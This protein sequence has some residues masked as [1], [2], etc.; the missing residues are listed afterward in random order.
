[1]QKHVD[2]IHNRL[3]STSNNQVLPIN[4]PTYQTLISKID[5]LAENN[6]I[7]K[8]ELKHRDEQ[9]KHEIKE[10]ISIE[11][12]NT[13]ST[14]ITN[15]QILNVICVTNHDNYLDMLTDRIGD[16]NQ[17]IDYIKDCALSDLSGDCK[18]IEK[19]YGNRNDEISFSMN[20]KKSKILYQNE[21]NETTS[22]NKDLFG[23]KLANNL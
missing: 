4:D 16:F 23:R 17:A 20:H 7:L 1:M 13:V 5:Q 9:L 22:E 8:S 3:A 21:R 18:L 15:N 19:I 14:N 10:Q 6:E 11:L 2:T 12:K